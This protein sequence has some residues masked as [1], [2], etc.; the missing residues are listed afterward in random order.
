MRAR[1][2]GGLR[3]RARRVCDRYAIYR[4]NLRGCSKTDCLAL[5]DCEVEYGIIA[6]GSVVRENETIF[7]GLRR[8]GDIIDTIADYTGC[9]LYG[10]VCLKP[11]FASAEQTKRTLCELALVLFDSELRDGKISDSVVA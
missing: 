8:D 1:L 3:V 4:C 5:L 6:A 9:Y 11:G 10:L 2:A 7:T